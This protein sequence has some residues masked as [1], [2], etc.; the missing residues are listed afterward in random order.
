MT[1]TLALGGV[2][3]TAL[4]MDVLP[5]VTPP[6]PQPACPSLRGEPCRTYVAAGNGG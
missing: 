2:H 1:D 3:P 4:V 6:D 5:S